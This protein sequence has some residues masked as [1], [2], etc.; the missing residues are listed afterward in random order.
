MEFYIHAANLTFLVSFLVRDILKLRALSIVG[1]GFLVAYFLMSNPVLWS[2]IGWNALF[3]AINLVQITRLV[4]ERRPVRLSPEE[5][6]LHQLAMRALTPH[7]MRRLLDVVLFTDAAAGDKLVDAG[8]DPGRLLVVVEGTLDVMVK[9]ERVATLDVG[10]F[11][12][13]MTF[14][15]AVPPKADVVASVRARLAAI[16][17]GKLRALLASNAELGAAMQGILGADLAGKLRRA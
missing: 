1:G 7:Q 11:A 15:T 6:R 12:G 16:D 8:V 5:H 13:E 3:T 17:T 10:Q 9:G 2:G 14:L 4:L